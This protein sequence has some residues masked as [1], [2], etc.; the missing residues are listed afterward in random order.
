MCTDGSD[1]KGKRGEIEG[2]EWQKKDSIGAKKTG[3]T[4]VEAEQFIR[5]LCS[6]CASK[7]VD[8][9]LIQH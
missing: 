2:T 1:G 8:L 7:H 9:V 4:E 3:L 5:E 6:E